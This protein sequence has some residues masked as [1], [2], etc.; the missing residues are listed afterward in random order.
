MRPDG[1]GV[2]PL[3][4][5]YLTL[6]K[7]VGGIGGLLPFVLL[8]GNELIGYGTEPSMS[9][10]YYTPMRNVWIGALCT[11]G[12]FLIAYDGWDL[13]D[14]IITNIAGVSTLGVALCPTTPLAGQ[15]TP[16]EMTVGTFHLAF[17]AVAFLMLG[18]MSLRFAT[19][20]VMP[21][22]LPLLKRIGCALGFTPPGNSAATAAEITVYRAS[23]FVILVGVAIFYPMTKAGWDWLLVLEAVMLV[24]FGVAWFLKGTT[25]PG[26]FGPGS[27]PSSPCRPADEHAGGSASHDPP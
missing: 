21:P 19:R 11:L 5:S 18:L 16:R 8:I 23:G 2:R 22:G 20:T 14:K 6:R 1:D 24:A 10:Y 7:C 17:A 27:A 12:I 15:V 9:A 26:R 25:L 4:M 13:L 3:V